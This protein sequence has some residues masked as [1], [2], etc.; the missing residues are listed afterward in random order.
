M[1]LTITQAASDFTARDFDSWGVELRSR[2]NA[3]FPNWT[4]FNIPNFGNILLE[5][6]AHTLDVISFT[7][8]Q[9]F[10]ETRI[11]WAQLRKSMIHLGRNVGFKLPGAVPSTVDLTFQIADG[12][13]RTTTITIPATTVIQTPDLAE[14]VE[15]DLI[16]DA[17]IAV[18]T[19]EITGQSAENAMSYFTPTQPRPSGGSRSTCR[20]CPST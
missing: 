5:L 20:D 8:D 10:R 3:A 9:Q 14:K 13:T 18:G 7:Q 2:A 6:F 1:A 15:F 19:T 4:D 11:A 17:V 16:A 12:L